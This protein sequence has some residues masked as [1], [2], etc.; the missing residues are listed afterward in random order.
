[1]GNNTLDKVTA[2]P[3]AIAA[4]YA[5]PLPADVHTD[6]IAVVETNVALQGE[7]FT[8]YNQ[9][10]EA[11]GL[12]AVTPA[13][14]RVLSGTNESGPNASVISELT[15]DISVI[16]GAVPNST[17]LI[18]SDLAGTPY[19]AYQQAFFDSVN[20]PAVLTSSYP[21]AGQAT[22]QSPFQWAWQ[23]LF[24]DGA[25]ANV[26]VHMAGGDQGSS[27]GVSTGCARIGRV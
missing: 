19:N 10:R 14:F 5:F 13:Q 9:Y 3:A 11:V 23:Q 24:V 2:T 7:L 4:N 22:A 8:A 1:V 16:A 21:I 27:C 12:S 26:S 18:Y 25:L 15:L 20:H 17:Q 6:P